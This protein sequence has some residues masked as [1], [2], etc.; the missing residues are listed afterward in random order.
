MTE[1]ESTVC[2]HLYVDPKKKKMNKQ[3]KT[4]TGSQTQSKLAVTRWE[5]G[6]QVKRFEVQIARYKINNKDVK[7]STGDIVNIS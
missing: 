4:E 1:K 5:R 7:Y 6:K 2:F 3:N